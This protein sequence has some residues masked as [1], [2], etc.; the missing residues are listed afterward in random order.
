MVVIKQA[1]K[2]LCV[3][4][5]KVKLCKISQWRSEFSFQYIGEK[6]LIKYQESYLSKDFNLVNDIDLASLFYIEN[7]NLVSNDEIIIENIY[8]VEYTSSPLINAIK[9][10]IS[11]EELINFTTEGGGINLLDIY[12]SQ[13]YVNNVGETAFMYSCMFGRIDIIKYL[14]EKGFINLININIQDNYGQ[15][16]FIHACI[17]DKIEVIKYLIEIGLINFSNV[18]IQD[19]Y[20]KTAFMRECINDKIDIIN[21]LIKNNLINS[22]NINIRNADGKTAYD[23][24]RSEEIKNII[25]NIN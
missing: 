4:D 18:N 19:N 14:V 22:T 21:H 25:K 15:T 3:E 23:L 16:A 13:N 2:F 12:G 10:K 8:F 20:G 5:S 17:F 1:D 24:A 11:F 7:N 9:F 6:F